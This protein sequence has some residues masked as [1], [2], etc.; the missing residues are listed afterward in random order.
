MKTHI[1]LIFS[2]VSV[3]CIRNDPT[4]Y[5]RAKRDTSGALHILTNHAQPIHADVKQERNG[6][7]NDKRCSGN[8]LPAS[9]EPGVVFQVLPPSN[10]GYE[11][12]SLRKSSPLTNKLDLI[13]SISRVA[14]LSVLLISA[15]L[16]FYPMLQHLYYTIYSFV[17]FK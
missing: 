5:T 4:V 1:L 8:H 10:V 6:D 11:L 13:R 16:E 7:T 2:L 14:T 9:I 17:Y 15:I 12:K 3:R